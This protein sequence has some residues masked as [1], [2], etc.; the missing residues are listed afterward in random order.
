MQ[1]ARFTV[2]YWCV[3]IAA[4]LPFACAWLAKSS[5]LGQTAQ[6]GW[7]RQPRPARLAGAADRLASARQRGAGQ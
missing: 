3:L 6:A 4:L 2:A 5:G 1:L 7:F